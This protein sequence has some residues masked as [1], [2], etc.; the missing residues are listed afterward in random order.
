MQPVISLTVLYDATCGLCTLA[1]DWLRKQSPLIRLKFLAAGST[2]ARRAFPQIPPGEL[3][4]VANTGEVWLG[5]SAWIVCL[6]A[7]RGYRDLAFRLTSPLLLRLAR[8]AFFVV[9]KNRHALS[10]RLALL[11]EREM[12]TQLRNIAVPRCQTEPK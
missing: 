3:A 10:T 7:T 4:V 9:S 11:G 2:E 8:E 12:E 5:N 1:E 6:W